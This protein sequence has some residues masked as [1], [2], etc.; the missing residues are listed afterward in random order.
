M[1]NTR[2]NVFK[3]SHPYPTLEDA[4]VTRPGSHILRSATLTAAMVAIAISTTTHAATITNTATSNGS[5]S[6][7][8]S[9]KWDWASAGVTAGSFAGN[10]F[11][12]ESTFKDDSKTTD[13][14]DGASLTVRA[15]LAFQFPNSSNI[16]RT[17]TVDNLYLD[18]GDINNFGGSGNTAKIAGNI[19]VTADS[20]I[21]S[22]NI[23]ESRHIQIDSRV[24]DDG[25]N[26][27]V[28]FAGARTGA[29]TKYTNAGNTFNG[30]WMV[31]GGQL[32][33]TNA[34]SV[35]GANINATGSLASVEIA[36]D[37]MAGSILSVSS[38]ATIKVASYDW[39]VSGLALDGNTVSAGTYDISQLNALASS[40]SSSVAFT[41]STGTITVSAIPEPA[42][43]ALLGIVGLMLLRRRRE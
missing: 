13:T 41:G 36:G 39:T 3:N 32:V 30:V 38:S 12:I 29:V 5:G 18:G 4:A 19:T 23:V 24:S 26:Y 7:E 28:L 14:F 27:D 2:S 21:G 33:F 31:T 43:L 10:D 15:T 37:W 1:K 9:S 42:S 20:R 16:S 35:G 40:F 17:Y 6:W 22:N 25:G 8:T 11:V 34:G